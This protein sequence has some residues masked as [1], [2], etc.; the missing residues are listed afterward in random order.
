MITTT[1]LQLGFEPEHMEVLQHR[2]EIAGHHR[3]LLEHAS[4]DE[5]ERLGAP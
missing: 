1:Q 4:D 5:L 3:R 2:I